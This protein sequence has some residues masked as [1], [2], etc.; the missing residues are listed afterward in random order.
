VG[1]VTSQLKDAV[2]CPGDVSVPMNDGQLISPSLELTVSDTVLPNSTMLET[3]T[4]CSA[5]SSA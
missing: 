2:P 4:G 1:V 3:F 5:E